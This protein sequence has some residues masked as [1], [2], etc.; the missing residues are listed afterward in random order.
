MTAIEFGNVIAAPK[1][2]TIVVDCPSF[3]SVIKLMGRVVTLT[4]QTINSPAI[5][6]IGMHPIDNGVEGRPHDVDDWSTGVEHFYAFVIVVEVV[7]I[8]FTALFTSQFCMHDAS[9]STE[10][11][12]FAI[13]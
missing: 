10:A 4:E 5:V 11:N 13:R 1:Y 6:S 2:N 9:A 8:Y 7:K 12:L 3:N